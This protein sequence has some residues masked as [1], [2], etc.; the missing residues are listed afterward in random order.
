MHIKN[1]VI[2]LQKLLPFFPRDVTHGEAIEKRLKIAIAEETREDLKLLL[3]SWVPTLLVNSF[4]VQI[5][6]LLLI[7]LPQVLVAARK[8]EEDELD[9][10]ERV[11]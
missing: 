1:V 8:A 3:Q 6:D 11:L 2:V 4:S 7:F 9:P 10:R 5:A